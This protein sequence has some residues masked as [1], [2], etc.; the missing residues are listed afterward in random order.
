[1][2][3]RELP[4]DQPQRARILRG[5]RTMMAS[6]LQYQGDDGLWRQIIDHP[7]AWPETSG[8]GRFT[9]AIVTGVK[10]GWLDKNSYGPAA[11]KAWL[12]LITYIDPDAEVRNVCIGTS[13]AYQEV[14]S[15]LEGQLKFYLD[16]DRRKGD[17]H[18]QA[19][20]LWT[21]SALMR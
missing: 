10:N 20:I 2:L 16:R 15:N 7:E 19:P 6:L 9:F 4:K 12:G 11:R 14:G 13:K 5:Y 8:P 3:L 17:L 1:E 18:G 21:A